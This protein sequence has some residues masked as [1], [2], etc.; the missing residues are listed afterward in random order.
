[1]KNSIFDVVDNKVIIKPEALLISP[2]KEIWANKDKTLANNQI[3]YIWFFSDYS[4][5]YH[6]HPEEDRSRMILNDVIKDK[7]F[8]VTKELQEAV[9]KYRELNTTPA[10]R[11]LESVYESVQRQ[12]KFFKDVEYTEDNIEKIQRSIIR[13][14]ELQEAIKKAEENCKKEEIGSTKR[15]GTES[16]AMFEE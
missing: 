9:K 1:M 13:M 3:K 7:T 4:S 12:D 6:K 15:R 8:K 5:V 14:P 16:T 2:F 10:L 11:L